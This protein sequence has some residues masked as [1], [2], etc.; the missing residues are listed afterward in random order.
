MKLFCVKRARMNEMKFRPDDVR[1]FGEHN[2]GVFVEAVNEKEAKEKFNALLKPG[3]RI[4]PAYLTGDVVSTRNNSI[5]PTRKK[6]TATDRKKITA[7]QSSVAKILKPK[8]SKTF[9]SQCGNE[10]EPGNSGFSSCKEHMP[11]K[12]PAAKR[13][14]RVFQAQNN[15]WRQVAFFYFKKDAFEYAKAAHAAKGGQWQVTHSYPSAH[16]A[17]VK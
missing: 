8:F 14:Y 11:R 10:F 6:L 5:K 15:L 4:R 13:Y 16:N 2:T 1:I 9:C 12:N 17:P 7:Y 3:Q